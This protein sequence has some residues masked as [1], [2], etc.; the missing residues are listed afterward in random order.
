M[1]AKSAPE[2]NH[3]SGAPPAAT[4][5]RNTNSRRISDFQRFARVC[6]HHRRG[7]AGGRD[8]HHRH[9]RA[10][11]PEQANPK[12]PRVHPQTIRAD[13]HLPPAPDQHRL[14]RR[15]RP[16]QQH[17]RHRRRQPGEIR[18]QREPRSS[19]RDQRHPGGK[20]Q[21]QQR[22]Q[23]YQRLRRRARWLP[24]WPK[25]QGCHRDQRHREAAAQRHRDGARE[26]Q[27]AVHLAPHRRGVVLVLG[28]DRQQQAPHRGEGD[29]PHRIREPEGDVDLAQSGGARGAADQDG[30]HAIPS[31]LQQSAGGQRH[32]DPQQGHDRA[33][34]PDCARPPSGHCDQHQC[35]QQR[36]RRLLDDRRPGSGVA[37]GEGDADDHAG[38]L[39]DQRACRQRAVASLAREQAL[40]RPAH[41]DEWERDREQQRH[42]YQPRII[43]HPG[44]QPAGAGLHRRRQTAYGG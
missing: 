25:D 37:S 18:I 43:Q 28:Q 14:P 31:D 39:A 12:R 34:A 5:S 24:R 9:A 30:E 17:E 1:S 36:S 2:R 13:E 3:S 20:H 32:A 41:A 22:R 16:R 11:R 8:Q 33:P 26:P 21:C 29:L 38:A 4:T 19:N 6:R 44:E 10:Q 7:D 27:Q 15:R 42:L 23:G 35:R 40:Q